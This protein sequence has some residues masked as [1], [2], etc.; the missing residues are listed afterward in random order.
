MPEKSINVK[1]KIDQVETTSDCLSDRAGL[2]LISRYIESTKIGRILANVFAFIKKSAKGTVLLS[3]FHQ[4][5]CFFFD[6]SNL[7]LN[8]FDDLKKDEGYAAIIET[9]PKQMASSHT[10]KRFFTA[11][12]IIRVWLF[13]KILQM[14]F[15]W[16][17]SIEKP[18]II[19]IGIDTMVMDNDDALKRE[20]VYPTY[21]KV[22]GFQPL[23]MYWGR[24]I[25][26]AI[27]RNGKVHSNHGNHVSLMVRNIVKLIRKH[28]SK[29][30]PI[31][32]LADAGFF[33]NELF[34]LCDCLDL[35]FVIGGKMYKDIKTFIANLSDEEFFEYTKKGQTWLFC[36]FTDKRKSWDSSWRTIYTKPISDEDGQILLEF[37]RPETII[38]TNI[39]MDNS[40]TKNILEAKGTEETTISPQAIITTYHSRGRDELVNR[41]LKDFGAEQLPFKRFAPNAAF[42]YMM[43][44]SFFL[45]ESF[46]YDID[47]EIIPLEW[48]ATT[49]RR[50]CLDI[51]GKIVRT[52]RKIIMKIAVTAYQILRFDILWAK[53]ICKI[54]IQ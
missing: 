20:G 15:L 36:E 18:K 19:K 33:D 28:Y 35:G 25:I 11:I 27:F 44:I 40:I 52:G 23:Q 50:R 37:A 3:L 21:K 46:K 9:S 7:H 53:S 12:S 8:Y 31:I 41:G 32:L 38:Y 5:I 2:S 1:Q 10:V 43:T 34:S 26:D 22:K 13:R 45:F 39:G 48:Y 51:A 42:Y 24:Y 29:D 17:L 54:P 49:F 4:L 16:R 14:L 30:V 6:G 47:S